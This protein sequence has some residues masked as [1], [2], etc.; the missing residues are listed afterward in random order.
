MAGDGVANA[1]PELTGSG[2]VVNGRTYVRASW[3]GGGGGQLSDGSLPLPFKD[4][5]DANGTFEVQVRTCSP[6]FLHRI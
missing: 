5:T 6:W 4:M 2:M 3:G 1:R